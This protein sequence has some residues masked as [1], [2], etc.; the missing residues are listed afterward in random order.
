MLEGT[1]QWVGERAREAR[2]WGGGLGGRVKGSQC[3]RG[4]LCSASTAAWRLHCPATSMRNESSWYLAAVDLR[5]A[6]A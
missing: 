3:M 5:V 1:V 6:V 4:A 2:R